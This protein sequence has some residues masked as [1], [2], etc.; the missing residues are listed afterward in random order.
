MKIIVDNADRRSS[1]TLEEYQV[2]LAY[3]IKNPKQITLSSAAIP[4]TI[5]PIQT[6]YNDL[7]NFTYSGAKSITI[8]PKNYSGA[9][10]AA[11]IQALLQ[12]ATSNSD[13]T[14]TYDAQTNKLTIG[15]TTTALTILADTTSLQTLNTLGF[16]ANQATSGGG[17]DTFE[18]TNQLDLSY[19]RYLNLDVEFGNNSSTSVVSASNK[20]SYV[21]QFGKTD[22]LEIGEFSELSNYVQTARVANYSF[23]TVKVKV[24]QPHGDAPKVAFL[25]GITHNLIFDIIG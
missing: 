13:P 19:P 3:P 23:D 16:T 8:V 10:L 17:L 21:V 15:T 18:A 5:Y 24:T 7:L 14:C 20:R 1:D 2:N 25:N 9:Q 22:F 6:G 11:A 12:A 4:K